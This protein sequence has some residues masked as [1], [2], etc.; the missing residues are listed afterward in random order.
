MYLSQ[1]SEIQSAIKKLS[2]FSRLWVDTETADWNTKHPKL[3]LIQVS[4]TPDDTTGESVYLFD[5][6]HQ[7]E[8]VEQF[9]RQIMA[10]PNIEKVFHNAS[11]DLRFLGKSQSQNVTCTY[12]LARKLAKLDRLKLDRNGGSRLQRLPNL[13]LK[14]LARELCHFTD[15]DTDSQSS[16]WRR[17]P[18]TAEQLRYAKLDVVY[19][20]H[21]HR[22]LLDLSSPMSPHFTATDVRVALECP[23]LFYLGHRLNRKTLFLP[24]TQY[25][26]I[27]N[28][29]HRLA[30]QFI[31]L[32]LEDS[33][34]Q[35]LLSPS[36]EN[37]NA[38]D[39]AQQMQHLFYDRVF[40]DY[41]NA[42]IAKNPDF[43][44]TLPQIWLGLQGLIRHYAELLIR[45][46]YH[47]HGDSVLAETF[48]GS[49]LKLHGTYRLPDGTQQE[50]RGQFDNLIYDFDGQR[51][52]VV[53]YK[54]YQGADPSAQVL[55]V[56]LYAD[57]LHQQ[58]QQPIDAAV[59]C[60]LPQFQA[61]RYDWE[62]LRRVVR[63]F[64]PQRLQEM[65]EW[66]RWE[67]DSPNPPPKTANRH[68]CEICPQQKSCQ[69]DFGVEEVRDSEVLRDISSENI[70]KS[71]SAVSST[72]SEKPSSEVTL[73]PKPEPTPEP[74]ADEW[75][76]RLVEVFR[77]FGVDVSYQG[78]AVGPSFVRVKLKPQLG[79]KVSSLL[80]LSN[81]LQV[82]LGIESPPMISPQ[83]GFVSVDLPRSD[84]QFAL[85]EQYIRRESFL[86]TAPVRI[87]IGV[88]LEGKLVEA[89]LSDP[90]T[91]H[92]LVGGTTGSGKSEFLRAM[93]LSLIQRRSP[94]YLKIA[95]V[96]PKR[97]TFP[98]F[99]KMPWLLSPVVK[100]SDRAVELMSELVDEMESRYQKFEASGCNDLPKYN[101]YRLKT[102]KEPEPPI[103]CI[104]DEYADF[105]ADLEVRKTLEYSI[106]RLGAMARAA[107]IH[108]IITTQ[109]PEAQVVTPIIRSNLPGRVALR[110]SSEA[111]SDIILGAK[112]T[113]AN[114]LL[115]KGDLLYS[116]GSKFYRLQS[117][118]ARKVEF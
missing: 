42:E 91:C 18:L 60:V 86:P 16:D 92:F 44:G 37:L 74:D 39:L 11:Y 118:F 3:S 17:R 111:D 47:C 2:H 107:G 103:V 9:V 100:D 116:R 55:Q 48:I 27:G 113:Q 41:T 14:T 26:G 35:A 70:S 96:D 95:L 24:D 59:Y 58:K 30:H 81:D 46:R 12:Q 10:N 4:A 69:N 25:A 32:A 53:E 65:R 97:V 23:R 15:I 117:L 62:E 57:L 71:P 56:G 101:Q 115:G 38:D 94:Q 72:S 66:V 73:T 77:A 6:L 54:T 51:L 87:A 36:A 104:F 1:R 8:S 75:G 28:P 20:S 19:L 99:E 88:N 112:K 7:P 79:V 89:D 40:Y 31:N 85:F 78:S 5:V 84:R 61:Y 109:R 33:R 105:M 49:E 68:L 83:A 76:T 13:K 102:G 22:S 90:N 50:I 52:R 64:L 67:F 80:R 93:L 106:K 82:Q 63:N 98:E 34:F 110:T 108:L 43:V 45:N 114:N 21:V 29:F